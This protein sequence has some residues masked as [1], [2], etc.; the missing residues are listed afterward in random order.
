MKISKTA[1]LIAILLTG[2]NILLAVSGFA[3][4]SGAFEKIT[5]AVKEYKIDTSAVPGDKKTR[6]IIA[7]R[8]AKGGFNINEA[9]QYKLGEELQKKEKPA[10]ELQKMAAY[11]TS[12]PG[13]QQ[14][15]NAIIWIYRNTFS[16]KEL[17]QLVKFYRSKTGQKMSASFPVIMLESLAA[18][19]IIQKK[20]SEGK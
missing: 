17:K 14:L 11:F 6:K 13:K 12:G 8:E 3:Q 20:F 10:D 5:T 15:D 9:I 2:C 7:L 16:Y 18:A 4:T 19:E 1:L